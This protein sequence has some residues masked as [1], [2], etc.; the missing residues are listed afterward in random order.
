MRAYN[1]TTFIFAITIFCMAY[2]AIRS[3][4][5]EGERIE[6]CAKECGEYDFE[7]R[8]SGD[9]EICVCDQTKIRIVIRNKG[10]H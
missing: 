5:G 7:S 10:K 8:T 4:R 2:I 3:D 6:R 1:F 9:D